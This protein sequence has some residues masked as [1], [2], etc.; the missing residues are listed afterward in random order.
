MYIHR[1]GNPTSS[2]RTTLAKRGRT[3]EGTSNLVAR[4][5][6]R[7]TGSELVPQVFTTGGG[8][9]ATNTLSKLK[10]L[11]PRVPKKYITFE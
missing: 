10:S 7:I 5:M 2:G 3:L 1:L 8:I 6:K 9:K 11:K 4:N